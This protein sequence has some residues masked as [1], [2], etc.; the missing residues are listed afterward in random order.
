MD[1]SDFVWNGGNIYPIEI[2]GTAE[3]CHEIIRKIF[4][5]RSLVE[6]YHLTVSNTVNIG[7]LLP[8]AFFYTYAFSR[9]KEHVSGDIY[10]ALTAGNYGNLI[11]GLYGWHLALPVNGFICP[12]TDN[13]QLDIQ[14]NCTVLDSVVPFNKRAPADPSDPSN[15]ERL[16]YLF[17]DYAPMMKNFVFPAKVSVAQKEEACKKLF[18]KYQYL[19]NESTSAAYAAALARN[20]IV[21]ADD[22]TVV[23]LMRHDPSHSAS[24]IRR[25][26][27]E[28]PVALPNTAAAQTPVQLDK[29]SVAAGDIEY[30]ISVLNSLNLLRMF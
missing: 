6:K 29:P 19:A 21:E 7:R 26:V 2:D 30:V 24:F 23:L 4:A 12:T 22:G 3:D 14:G 8:Q 17:H 28:T 15:L 5:D 10:Y 13:L 18:M 1:E 16:E 25:S 27:G 20:E 11:S 9:L